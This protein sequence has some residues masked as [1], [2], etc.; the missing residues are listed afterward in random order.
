M[1]LVFFAHCCGAFGGWRSPGSAPTQLS[2]C[3]IKGESFKERVVSW[4]AKQGVCIAQPNKTRLL[5]ML[6]A[7]PYWR[8]L[9]AERCRRN[10]PGGVFTMCCVRCVRAIVRRL[11]SGMESMLACVR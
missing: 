9:L 6:Y 7:V 5:P 1:P 3:C 2:A 8:V 11:E 4:R 10:P